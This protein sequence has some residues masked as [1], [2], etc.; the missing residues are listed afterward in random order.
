VA[1]SGVRLFCPICIPFGINQAMIMGVFP[2][3]QNT[4]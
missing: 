2:I 3:V 1:D 4:L